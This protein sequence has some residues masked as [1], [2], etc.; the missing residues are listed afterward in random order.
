VYVKTRKSLFFL[1]M[2]PF[3]ILIIWAPDLFSF[4]LG[5]KWREAG[6]YARLLSPLYLLRFINFPLSFIIYLYRQL[7]IDLA[8]TLYLNIT[9]LIILISTLY[10]FPVTISLLCFSINYSLV[11]LFMLNYTNRLSK[12]II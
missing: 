9:N 3:I 1:S 6:V 8:M 10:F 2:F 12:Q 11:Y 5:E 4:F 7:K